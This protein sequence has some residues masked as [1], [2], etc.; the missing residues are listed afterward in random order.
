MG[1]VQSK[2]RDKERIGIGPSEKDEIRGAGTARIRWMFK[3]VIL[4]LGLVPVGARI[5]KHGPYKTI[6]WVQVLV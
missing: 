3:G 5:C 6:S 1:R 2:E 4:A